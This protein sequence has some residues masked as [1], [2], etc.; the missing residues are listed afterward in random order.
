VLDRLG[1]HGRDNDASLSERAFLLVANRLIAPGSEHGLARWL[2]TD[3]VCDQQ[4]RRWLPAWRSEAERKAS[5]APRVRVEPRQ[6]Q[7][8]YRTLD[9]LLERKTKI[10]HELYLTLRDLASF[11]VL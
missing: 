8:W 6:L 11:Q 3:F 5:K 1:G 10:E 4:G 9:Q 2:E 7:W